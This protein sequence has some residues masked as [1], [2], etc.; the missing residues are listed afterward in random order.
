MPQSPFEQLGHWLVNFGRQ[1]PGLS[2]PPPYPSGFPA[3]VQAG[4]AGKELTWKGTAP[5]LPSTADDA[6]S[7]QAIWSPG[8]FDLHPELA[9]DK[10]TLGQVATPI[11]GGSGLYVYLRC[12]PGV[13]VSLQ[14]LAITF[15]ER[16]SAWG[17][18]NL[19]AVSGEQDVSMNLQ[20]G[21]PPHDTDVIDPATGLITP[22]ADPQVQGLA[23]VLCLAPP[24]N[25]GPIRYWQPYLVFNQWARMSD[26]PITLEHGWY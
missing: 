8:L 2:S 26:P 1:N 19:Y 12:K 11:L 18:N 24:G 14:F 6:P 9:N 25:A 5:E 20:I 15:Y 4:A 17:F 13:D 16:A 7:R 23:G 3:Q 21:N 22:A 10:S